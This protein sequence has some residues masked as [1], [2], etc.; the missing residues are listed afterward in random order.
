MINAPPK[1]TES[2]PKVVL[3]LPIFRHEVAQRGW[4]SGSQAASS[5][6]LLMN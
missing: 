6:T 5:N 2:R 4:L 3:Q 1:P